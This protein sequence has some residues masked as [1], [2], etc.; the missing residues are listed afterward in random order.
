MGD[1]RNLVYSSDVID[2]VAR[3]VGRTLTGIYDNGLGASLE[4]DSGEIVTFFPE[5]VWLSSKLLE[6]V[7]YAW[8]K[9]VVL[10]EPI[11]RGTQ[12]F[13]GKEEIVSA[14]VIESVAFYDEL[15][16]ELGFKETLGCY[17]VHPDAASKVPPEYRHASIQIGFLLRTS[18]TF[19]SLAAYENGFCISPILISSLS[20]VDFFGNRYRCLT[21]QS[22]GPAEAGR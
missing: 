15:P 9:R 10:H 1:L 14:E 8:A 22:S 13:K 7:G 19:I 6:E 16:N 21:I 17:L 5:E 11:E 18:S 20:E 2:S 12:I 3:L 4:L